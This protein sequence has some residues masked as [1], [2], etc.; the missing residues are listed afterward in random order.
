MN[1]VIIMETEWG[2]EYA[3][4]VKGSVSLE[5]FTDSRI[6]AIYKAISKHIYK[7]YAD[8]SCVEL[9]V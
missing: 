6:V 7:V 2:L 3:K 4:T 5:K 9:E 1:Y 8:S